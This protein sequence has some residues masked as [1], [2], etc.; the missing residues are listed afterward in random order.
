MHKAKM[1]LSVLAMT[2]TTSAWACRQTEEAGNRADSFCAE[3]NHN[4]KRVDE[5]LERTNIKQGVLDLYLKKNWQELDKLEKQYIVGFP[6]TQSGTQKLVLFYSAFNSTFGDN[7]ELMNSIVDEWL[8]SQPSSPAAHILKA[9]A[10]DAKALA[11]RGEGSIDSVDPST[12]PEI[13][14]LFSEEKEYL[15]KIKPVAASDPMW[16][17]QMGVVARYLGDSALMDKI[18]DEGSQKFPDYQNIYLEAVVMALPKWGGEPE[19]IEKIARLAVSKTEKRSGYSLYAYLWH[20]AFRMQ[21]ELLRLLDEHRIVSWDEMKKGWQDR[22]KQYPTN[23]TVTK[24]MSNA[25]VANDKETFTQA[26]KLMGEV[27][28][29]LEQNAWLSGTNYN[30]CVAYLR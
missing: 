23:N 3:V 6:T 10:L 13:Q 7:V 24:F 30:D 26:Y 14:R 5:M 17:Q 25:C 28:G 2:L 22:Y 29:D 21:P 1:L 12:L 11:L 20:N 16:Y 4:Y 8:S 15:I 18:V 27:Y 9:M 19:K